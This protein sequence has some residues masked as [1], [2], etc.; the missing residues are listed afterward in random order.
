MITHWSS[1]AQVRSQIRFLNAKFPT[2]VETKE[3]SGDFEATALVIFPSVKG[4]AQISFEFT[5]EIVVMW[6]SSIGELG[7][8]VK[9]VR[10]PVRFVL[11]SRL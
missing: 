4:S 5:K 9:S 1:C 2:T 7:C 3:R 8:S 6:P 11:P 10:G